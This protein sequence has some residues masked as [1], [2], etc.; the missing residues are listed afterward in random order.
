MVLSLPVARIVVKLGYS[1][2]RA[3]VEPT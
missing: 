3:E 1:F 2:D